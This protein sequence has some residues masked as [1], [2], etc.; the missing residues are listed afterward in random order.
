MAT[1]PG[2]GLKVVSVLRLRIRCLESARER[3]RERDENPCREV[4][5]SITGL[6]CVS[7]C[8][9]FPDGELIQPLPPPNARAQL[10]P[11][12]LPPLAA[13]QS[14]QRVSECH[15]PSPPVCVSA[16]ASASVR[17]PL[18]ESARVCFFVLC[19]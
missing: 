16:V 9:K 19:N 8:Y 3:E 10:T 4:T 15:C 14:P 18:S 12:T 17:V 13:A 11:Q 2:L 1:M 6:W 7:S 5:Q